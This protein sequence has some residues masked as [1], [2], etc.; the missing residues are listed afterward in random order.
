MRKTLLSLTLFLLILSA[1]GQNLIIDKGVV[2]KPGFYRTFLEFKTNTPSIEF[3]YTLSET[4]RKYGSMFA[5]GKAKFYRVNID[6]KKAKSIIG[7][8][9]GFCDGKDIYL[10][11]AEAELNPKLE[12]AKVTYLGRYCYYE[13]ID[14]TRIITA[15]GSAT[16][17]SLEERALDINTG[18]IL[19]LNKFSMRK[20]L[21]NDIGL[22]QDFN[23]EKK[24]DKSLKEYLVS[25]SEKHEGEIVK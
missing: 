10:S 11:R 5:T 9:Y 8:V 12:F 7:N 22:L 17:T 21:A 24:K 23:N 19:S 3:D 18:Q 15:G 13:V 14:A 20:L 16:Q 25:Y 2:M 4:E 6:K 1:N